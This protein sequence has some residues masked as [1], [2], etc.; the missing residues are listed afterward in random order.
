[1]LA[2]F[3]YFK[4]SSGLPDPKV[5]L[6]TIVS[7]DCIA[8]MNREV[9]EASCRIPSRKCGPYKTYSSSERLQIGK[10]AFQQGATAASRRFSNVLRKPVSCSTAKSMK[11]IMKR[12]YA[13]GDDMKAARDGHTLICTQA[14]LK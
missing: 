7:P 6:S 9:E 5:S 1:M 2:L 8:E 3:R 10:Y 11:R 13:R 14:V 12:S 4:P